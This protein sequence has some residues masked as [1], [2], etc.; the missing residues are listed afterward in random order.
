MDY[1]FQW[2]CFGFMWLMIF[3]VIL[4]YVGMVHQQA[5]PHT[6]VLGLVTLLSASF[7][8]LVVGY[9]LSFFGDLQ[10][11]GLFS[12]LSTGDTVTLL[13]QLLFPSRQARAKMSLR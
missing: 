6:L 12:Q 5:I 4:Y 2:I 7:C 10:H 9:S 11:S 1:L 13:V 8:W 3:G